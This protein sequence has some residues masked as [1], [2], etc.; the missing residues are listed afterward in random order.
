MLVCLFKTA[1]IYHF[2]LIYLFCEALVVSCIFLQVT[3]CKRL[4]FPFSPRGKNHQKP[5]R[6]RQLCN[7]PHWK[8]QQITLAP[9]VHLLPGP[10]NAGHTAAVVNHSLFLFSKL[11]LKLH[12]AFCGAGWGEGGGSVLLPAGG[13]SSCV[14]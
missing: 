7:E 13:Q 4:Y 6:G 3:F 11:A 9:A 1:K 12:Q 5:Q 2:S 8:V 14:R 10:S